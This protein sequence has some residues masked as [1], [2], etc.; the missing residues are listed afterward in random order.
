[1]DIYLEVETPRDLAKRLFLSFVKTP[2]PPTPVLVPGVAVVAAPPN[3]KVSL[4]NTLQVTGDKST[5]H[6]GRL[7]TVSVSLFTPENE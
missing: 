4:P 5:S 6:D 3:I 1:M 7:L 2:P